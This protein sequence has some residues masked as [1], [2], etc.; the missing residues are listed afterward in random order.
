MA[1]LLPAV[2]TTSCVNDLQ[3]DI[4][5]GNWNHE[6]QVLD[7]KF[8]NQ[9]GVATIET[10]DAKTG[11]ID[12]SINVDAVPDLSSIKIASLQLSYQ[13]TASVGVGDALNFENDARSASITV[14]AT[15]GE[16]RT[17]TITAGEFTEDILGTWEVG[18][19]WIWGGTGPEYGGGAVMKLSDKSWCWN[20]GTGPEAEEDNTLTFTLDGV[21]DEGNTYGTCVHDAGPDRK[22]F[23]AMYVGNNPETGEKVD[24]ARFYR[25]VPVGTSTWKRDYAAGTITFTGADGVTTTGS[26]VGAGTED[27]G[28]G[29]SFTVT[30]NALAFSLNGTDDWTNIYQD[31]D[32]F[33]KKP[34]KFWI[35][36]KKK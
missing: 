19:L 15:T 3:D 21:T 31:Y 35:P 13:A 26:F 5:D 34:R 9:V 24:V 12:I 10:L 16:T 1:L 33:V 29:K 27:L 28:Y 6:R 20:N 25:Q 36:L 14:Q 2:A 18:S 7:I 8:E 11:I 22:Y 30:D 23:D 4:N 32:K 17:Y